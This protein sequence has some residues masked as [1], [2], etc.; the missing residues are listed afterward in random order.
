MTAKIRY[1]IQAAESNRPKAQAAIDTGTGTGAMLEGL[2][3]QVR[4]SI[5]LR[6]AVL[7]NTKSMRKYT[8]M[9]KMSISI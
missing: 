1:D 3:A 5:E 4:S 6:K 8:R 7:F 9:H 2:H